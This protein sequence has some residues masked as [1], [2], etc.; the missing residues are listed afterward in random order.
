MEWFAGRDLGDPRR[1]ADWRVSPLREKPCWTRARGRLH[2]L[3]R[4]IARRGSADALEAAGVATK[5]YHGAG[6]IHGHLG[7]GEASESVRIEAQRARTDFR[8]M[9]EASK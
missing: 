1:G 3:V 6:L 7:L 9:L 5:R 2:G 4:S 8:A